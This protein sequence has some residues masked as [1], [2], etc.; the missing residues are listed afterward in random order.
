MDSKHIGI[1]FDNTIVLYDELFYELALKEGLIRKGSEKTK[2]AVRAALIKENKEHI[3]IE[4]QGIVYG[5]LI[6]DAPAQPGIQKVLHQLINNGYK[7]SI[8]SHKTKFPI[9]G[10][11]LDLHVAARNWLEING[12]NDPKIVGI[13]KKNIYFNETLE[14]KVSKIEEAGCGFFIDDLIK[15][16]NEL[17]NRIKKIHFSPLSK[18]GVM[19][20]SVIKMQSWDELIKIILDN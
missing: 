6:K 1:D 11:K 20:S 17:D 8:F 5:K 3:F 9:I 12:F 19:N 18:N 13:E 15:V 16:L 4:I 14:K 2:H 10:E 7:I